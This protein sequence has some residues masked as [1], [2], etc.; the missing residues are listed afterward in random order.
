MKTTARI[1]L[2][3]VASLLVIRSEAGDITGRITLSGNPPPERKIVSLDAAI[4]ARHPDGLTTC[5]YQVGAGS[6]LRNVLVYIRGDFEGRTFEPPRAPVVLD[7][8]DGLFQPFVL[9]VQ[10]GQPLQLRCS[11]KTI[12]SFLA[13]SKANPGFAISPIGDVV[14]RTFTKPEVAVRF[15]CDLHPWNYAYVGVF[16]H[17]FFTVTDQNGRYTIGAVPSGRYTLEIFHPKAGTAA[18]EVVVATEKLV[19]DFSLTPK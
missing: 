14:S 16:A 10:V 12:C 4:A 13:V 5:H 15:K 7:H 6:D 11:D 19:A 2:F 17:P 1:S 3:L 18:R 8:V 9:G